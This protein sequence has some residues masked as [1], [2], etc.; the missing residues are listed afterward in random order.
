MTLHALRQYLKYRMHARGRHGTH[1]PFVYY[2]VETVL[3]AV[4]PGPAD[5][6]QRLLAHMGQVYNCPV[7]MLPPDAAQWEQAL[8]QQL[9]ALQAGTII[10]VPYPHATPQHTAAW[11]ALCHTPGVRMSIDLYGMGML[12]SRPEFLVVQHFVVRY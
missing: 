8:H 6:Y 3:P 1:S 12:L 7:A 5:K 9:P 10:A 2:L 11:Q 4:P